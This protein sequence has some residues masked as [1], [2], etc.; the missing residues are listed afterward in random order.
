MGKKLYIRFMGLTEDANELINEAVDIS[1]TNCCRN[2]NCVC[3]FLAVLK[4]T[5]RGKKFLEHYETTYDE[6]YD[7]FKE[8]VR[9]KVYGYF[10]SSN[11]PVQAE[12][13]SKEALSL[14][15]TAGV[16]AVF[17]HI[18]SADEL[19]SSLLENCSQDLADFLEYIDM[20]IDEL[21]EIKE[22][23]FMIPE[24]L[25]DFVK[26]L[27]DS[28]IIH[29]HNFVDKHGYTDEMIEILSRKQ[30]AN[31]C[32]VGEAG[33][34]KTSAVY[35][36]VKRVIE[37]NNSVPE[38]LK[39]TH[40]CY[41]NGTM[42]IAGTCF[43][44]DFEERIRTLLSWAEETDC[45]IFLDEIHTFLNSDN[46]S[47]AG[48]MIK[49]YLSDGS[50]KIIGAT[51]T[52]EYHKYIEGDTA[53]DRRIQKVEFKEPSKE[54]TL[55][56]LY[57]SISNYEWY[58]KVDVSD[59]ILELSVNLADKYMKNKYFPDKAV[60][61]I[62]QACAKAK[63][64]GKKVVSEDDIYK[65]VSKL[66]T[67][68]VDR[69][70]GDAKKALIELEGTLGKRVIGQA[71]A[72]KVVSQAIRRSKAEVNDRKK[73]L[74]SF[75][76]VGPTGVGKT[77]LCRVLS[78]EVAI[79]DAP[80]IKIDMSEY[81]ERYDVSKMIGSAPGFVGYGEGGQLTEKVKHN[82]Y[83]I[84]LFDEIEKA[85]PD[86]FNIFLQILDEGKLTDGEGVTVDFTN[87]II[88]MT[89]NAGYGVDGM[90]RK[91][92]GFNSDNK[93]LTAKE[94]EKIAKEA[95]ESTFRP[96]LLNRLDN[97]IIFESLDKDTCK[98]ITR[99]G[100]DKLA[101]RVKES[102]DICLTYTD[103]AVEYITE[104]GYSDKYGARN[105]NREIQDSVENQLADM[106]L[107]D[108]LTSGSNAKIC[109]QSE[110]TGDSKAEMTT[111]GAGASKN[112]MTTDSDELIIVKNGTH[113]KISKTVKRKRAA[114]TEISDRPKKK[115][116]TVHPHIGGIV[117][118]DKEKVPAK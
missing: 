32:L 37:D 71:E 107:M 88:V 98:S 33:V 14:I 3:L 55:D 73:P 108:K 21:K 81:A 43:R 27:T 45:I 75:I 89:S 68:N 86:V 53:F 51:T 28:D 90:R 24:E 82:P 59:D 57:G 95:L 67:V 101:A 58:H 26:D 61:I 79:G 19:I 48:N 12:H 109:M 6:V 25:R 114:A 63:V 64:S 111:T 84:V 13:F 72:V 49:K 103:K 56:I 41:V 9:R 30:K 4:T 39:N 15:M 22:K 65:V 47:T 69:L 31:P 93:P 62:D 76:F 7:K 105:I 70:A 78:E 112:E 110:M 40:I 1:G 42:L 29:E 91:K 5:G 80:L 99:L 36:L 60:T 46:N 66:A 17:K 10:D 11:V 102:N 77:E 52:K 92:L 74:A 54:E 106:I 118:P 113:A 83:S 97:I 96:E 44:G 50:I 104:N 8:L 23:A 87:C 20:D 2:V 116:E 34:G 117:E 18:T 115:K 85:H 16:G 38:Y 94:K 100:L 35:A